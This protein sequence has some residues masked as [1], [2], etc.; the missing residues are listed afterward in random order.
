MKVCG[1]DVHKDSV[2]CAIY[3]GKKHNEVRNYATLTPCLYEMGEYLQSEGVHRIAM[4]STGIYWIPIWNVL[5]AMGF[6]LLLVNPYLIKQMPGR[7]SDVKD[8]QW[9][10]TLLYKDLL[11]SSLVPDATIRELRSYSR[12]Y[13]KLQQRRTSIIQQI[14]RTLEM[15]GI[16][17]T[18]YVSNNSGKSIDRVVKSIIAGEKN[19]E[20]LELLIHGR[21]RKKHGFQIR[22]A[23]TGFIVDHHRFTLELLDQER[24]LIEKQAEQCL[25]KMREICYKKY[26]KEMELLVTVPG[27]SEL[28]ALLLIA[29]TGA[30]MRAFESSNKFAGWT[31][32]RPRNDESAGKYKSTATT[33]G[34]KYLRTTLVQIAWAASRTK[35]SYFCN[36]FARLA[37]RKSRKK[38]LIAIARKIAVIIWNLLSNDQPYNANLLPVYDPDKIKAKIRYHQREEER[39]SKII[40][41]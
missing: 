14:E 41:T 22:K 11:R 38:A 37:M 40:T 35:G 1:L 7:K 18:S 9:I 15:C 21:I 8:A 33:K 34:N 39:L 24:S 4:E 5:E 27:I 16:R 12:K 29:E 26:S 31:G 10:A 17:I 36:K 2:F 32:L 23:L 19:P 20:E 28:S 30:D 3:N 13:V 6:E 25:E